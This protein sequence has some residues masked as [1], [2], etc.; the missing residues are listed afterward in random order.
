MLQYMYQ[1]VGKVNRMPNLRAAL[2]TV[3]QDYR[4][5]EIST[6]DE[7]HVDRWIS[8]FPAS[9]RDPILAELLHV[10]NFTY[11]TRANF[12]TFIDSAVI[13][14]ASAAQNANQ[15]WQGVKVLNLQN[16]GN[17]QKDMIALLDNSLQRQ[18]GISLSSCGLSPH[19]Y[20]YLDDA[21]FSGGRIR[22]DITNWIQNSAPSQANLTILVIATHSYG[23][24]D[25]G[26]K[27]HKAAQ[28]AGKNITVNWRYCASF[29]NRKTYISNS[30][31]LCPTS[32]NG[33]LEI[34]AYA[35]GLAQPPLIRALGGKSPMGI[36]SAEAGR[37][38]L[39]QEFLAGGLRVRD[40]CPHFDKYMRPLGRILLDSLGFGSMIVT[41]RNCPNNAPLVLWAGD[42]WY[43]LF[44]RKIN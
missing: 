3:I 39:E 36:F 5:G 4:S 43:P 37:N 13:K 32:A 42:P 16:A 29:E 11:F 9:V 44:P 15:F 35:A 2:A 10:L 38:I 21:L 28:S 23:Q 40:M 7:A 26:T 14:L 30:D 22:S 34:Q 25:T 17:S 33:S 24:W 31:I 41:Y 12:Q 20:L 6:P 8:Q 1:A 19:T 27:I 18:C